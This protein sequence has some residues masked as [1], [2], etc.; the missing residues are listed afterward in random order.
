[1]EKYSHNPINFKCFG[2]S[3]LVGASFAGECW[4]H[5]P[6]D[7]FNLYMTSDNTEYICFIKVNEDSF[8]LS[9]SPE[10]CYLHEDFTDEELGRMK[11]EITD[12][13][14]K[15]ISFEKEDEYVPYT[16][17]YKVEL[18]W[19]EYTPKITVITDTIEEETIR[20]AVSKLTV[21]ECELLGIVSHKLKYAISGDN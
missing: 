20:H 5:E 9:E 7:D 12:F 3:L 21:E 2:V 4:E 15:N 14:E 11:V 19:I 13:I 6:F 18:M 1:M 10:V 8:L 17:P 16:K